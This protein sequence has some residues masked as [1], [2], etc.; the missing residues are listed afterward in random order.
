M[1]KKMSE[2]QAINQDIKATVDYAKKVLAKRQKALQK[3]KKKAGE[4]ASA[5]QLKEMENKLMAELD[6]ALIIQSML[7][8]DQGM[9]DEVRKNL[10]KQLKTAQKNHKIR[11]AEFKKAS[12][13]AKLIADL[14]EAVKRQIE[15]VNLWQDQLDKANMNEWEI[16]DYVPQSQAGA[17]VPA[18]EEI[19]NEVKEVMPEFFAPPAEPEDEI[20]TLEAV[21]AHAAVADRQSAPLPGT[22][23]DII[24]GDMTPDPTEDIDAAEPVMP[25]A[26]EEGLYPERENVIGNAAPEDLDAPRVRNAFDFEDVT[27]QPEERL[28]PA[29]QVQKSA[30]QLAAE[31]KA[32]EEAAARQKEEE[33]AERKKELAFEV[34]EAMNDVF[35]EEISKMD[36]IHRNNMVIDGKWVTSMKEN[37]KNLLDDGQT[38]KSEE[39]SKMRDALAPFRSGSFIT[40][41]SRKHYISPRDYSLVE[42]Y[43]KQL[44]DAREATQHYIDMKGSQRSTRWGFGN[45]KL[46]M[47]RAQATLDQ[48]DQMLASLD[49][50]V[51]NRI[52]YQRIAQDK[53]EGDFSKQYISMKDLE[54]IV[55]PKRPKAVKK[56]NAA[57]A[58]KKQEAPA[59]DAKKGPKV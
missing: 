38:H 11:E 29:P 58:V 14:E 25:E 12:E 3:A 16:V 7:K 55:A 15:L 49:T 47:D 8:H 45:G 42:K 20:P 18:M 4:V 10:K 19:K 2:Q 17:E 13:K 30:E 31:K 32:A 44:Q 52:R 54:K 50:I 6:Q 23:A 9:T 59:K 43:Q 39:F 21:M 33:E 57:K 46:N 34:D 24:F 40:K 37:M 56:Q 41:I 22:V 28:A 48:L 51:L 5:D 35:E 36:R 53:L 26:E 27:P 1:P